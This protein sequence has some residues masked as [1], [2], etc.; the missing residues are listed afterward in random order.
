MDGLESDITQAIFIFPK[1]STIYIPYIK[2][3]ELHPVDLNAFHK[4]QYHILE[5]ILVSANI[6]SILGSWKLYTG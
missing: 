1:R 6:R 4:E 3:Y 2:K 5:Q